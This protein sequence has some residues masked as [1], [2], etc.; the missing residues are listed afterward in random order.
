MSRRKRET[1]IDRR[2]RETPEQFDARWR[3]IGRI[4][5]VQGFKIWLIIVAIVIGILLEIDLPARQP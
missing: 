3:E 5:C 1:W 2:R 4:A